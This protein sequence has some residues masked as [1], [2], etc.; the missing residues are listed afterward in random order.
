[1]LLLRAGVFRDA[2]QHY[3]FYRATLS[4][5][6]T[7]FVYKFAIYVGSPLRFRFRFCSVLLHSG[8]QQSMN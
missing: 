2:P 6:K 5:K 1:M 7:C 3:Y 4:G 8:D